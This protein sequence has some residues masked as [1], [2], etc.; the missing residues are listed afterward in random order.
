MSVPVNALLLMFAWLHGTSTL[1]RETLPWICPHAGRERCPSSTADGS[2]RSE[3][4]ATWNCPADSCMH[5]L[6]SWNNK[7]ELV[8]AGALRKCVQPDSRAKKEWTKYTLTYTF[9]NAMFAYVAQCSRC[10]STRP[11]PIG[12]F[13][14][15]HSA[16]H[17]DTCRLLQHRPHCLLFLRSARRP[18]DVCSSSS[19]SSAIYSFSGQNIHE[20]ASDVQPTVQTLHSYV[21]LC[22]AL[23]DSWKKHSREPKSRNNNKKYNVCLCP[24]CSYAMPS[25]C[26]YMLLSPVQKWINSWLTWDN[27]RRVNTDF[28]TVHISAYSNRAVADEWV[29]EN[30]YWAT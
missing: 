28:R 3:C 20:P 26:A 4:S 12:P 15:V 6:A 22:C 9:P 19:N 24:L 13:A 25:A 11:L 2:C 30:G 18:P 1:E 7:R 10:T 29:C 17:S 27:L 23:S 16:P 14:V 8:S 21:D 5:F